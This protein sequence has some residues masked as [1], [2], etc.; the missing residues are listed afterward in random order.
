MLNYLPK[1]IK[2]NFFY[3]QV[4]LNFTMNEK[5]KVPRENNLHNLSQ[6]EKAQQKISPS[7]PEA[8]NPEARKLN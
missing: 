5:R 7:T 1:N 4:I 8:A 6:K 2:L 3:F